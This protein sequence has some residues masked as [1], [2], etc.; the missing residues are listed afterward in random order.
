[1]LNTDNIAANENLHVLDIRNAIVSKYNADQWADRE[2][3]DAEKLQDALANLH[4]MEELALED[5]TLTSVEF[6]AGMENLK[7]LDITNNYV[8]SL[9]PLKDLPKLQIVVC[10][11]NPISDTAGL[12]E[13]LIN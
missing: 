2:N 8:T 7:M 1:M 5:L 10:D 12:D 3:I 4:G 9:T 13:I 11:T 6:A